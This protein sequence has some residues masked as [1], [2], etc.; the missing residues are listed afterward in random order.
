MKI[1]DEISIIDAFKI[2]DAALANEKQR[3]RVQKSINTLSKRL[4]RL[5]K[6]ELEVTKQLKVYKKKLEEI[7]G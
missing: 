4:K 6:T 2:I 7:E 3:Q 1:I 5:Q